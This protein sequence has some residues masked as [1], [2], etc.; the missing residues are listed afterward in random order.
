MAGEKGDRGIAGRDTAEGQKT[1][2]PQHGF[3]RLMRG[4]VVLAI[5]RLA[6]EG[7]EDQPPGI[8][9]GQRGGE[10]RHYKTVARHRTLAD[11]RGPDD[12]V[13]GEIPGGERE[14]G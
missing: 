13:L 14:A 10:E 4:L 3:R 9:R 11:Q 12:G 8:K 6:M 2:R 7:L 5:M 1:E